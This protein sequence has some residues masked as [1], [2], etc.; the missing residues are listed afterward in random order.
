MKIKLLP[1]GLEGQYHIEISYIFGDG[2]AYDH[3]LIV[4]KDEEEFLARYE[5]IKTIDIPEWYGEPTSELE[6]YED[7][8]NVPTGFE[9]EKKP[10]N[11][12][13]I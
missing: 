8:W 11:V 3:A 2:D 1:L 12:I 9:R 7:W 5:I 10:C 4:C 13:G 6:Q